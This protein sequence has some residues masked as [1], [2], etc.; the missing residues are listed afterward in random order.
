V[1]AR[2]LRIFQ[3]EI[4][5]QCEFVLLAAEQLREAESFDVFETFN[6]GDPATDLAE[7]RRASDRNMTALWSALQTI[8]V[9][10][11]NISKLLWGNK[12]KR[13]EERRELRDSLEI[14][15]T[16]CLRS[17]DLRNDFEHFDDRLRTWFASGQN[18]V[19]A[20]RNV[21]DGPIANVPIPEFG[22]YNQKTGEV[23]FWKNSA[24]VRDIVAEVARL[25][26]IAEREATK[27]VP[28]E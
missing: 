8:L 28:V 2:L 6:P 4:V 13:E 27:P 7:A 15:D 21:W 5:T 19:Y 18:H 16:S 14:D 3:G 11:A 20:G 10:A 9:S 25:L 23:V 26:P 1:E 17:P 22:T 24:N 12:G